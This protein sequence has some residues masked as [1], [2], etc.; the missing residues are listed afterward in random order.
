[1][2]I[3]KNSC[4]IVI[5]GGHGDLSFRKLLPALYHLFN[6]NY[7]DNKSRIIIISRQDISH[8]ENIKLIKTKLLKFIEDESFKEEVFEEFQKLLYISFIDFSN[9]ESYLD[10]KDLLDENSNEDRI[11]YLSTSPNFFGGICKSLNHWNLITSK[12]RVVLEKPIGRDLESSKLINKEVLKY[13][14]EG[15]IYRIDH[16]LGKDTVQNIIDFFD[17]I[18]SS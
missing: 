8:S 14:K 15:Q 3:I 9:N 16:Y 5:F 12:S 2:D 1:M 6:D 17:N 13:F 7:L 11:N 4:D 18:S 10:L